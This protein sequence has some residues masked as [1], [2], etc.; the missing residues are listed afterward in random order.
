MGY[1][2]WYELKNL[3]DP[4]AGNVLRRRVVGETYEQPVSFRYKLVTSAV[5][6]NRFPAVTFQDGDGVSF[7]HVE[8]NV[9]IPAST[10]AFLN[11]FV[12]CGGNAFPNSGEG[13]AVLP[14]I[15]MPPGFFLQADVTGIDPGDVISGGRLFV[16][17]YPS[18]EW[19]SSPG[20]VPYS[21]EVELEFG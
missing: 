20:A 19:S 15:L 14:Q 3:P 7:P 11:F 5:V 21:P 17:R 8:S 2:S 18:S 4:G 16:R 12:N 1:E 9:A 13:F 10:T 6:K